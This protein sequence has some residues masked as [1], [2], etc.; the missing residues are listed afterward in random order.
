MNS[1]LTS[2]SGSRGHG[3][4]IQEAGLSGEKRL[5]NMSLPGGVAP[6][7]KGSLIALLG[8]HDILCQQDIFLPWIQHYLSIIEFSWK[9]PEE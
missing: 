7:K 4:G 6:L 2:L 8:K 1:R 5:T 3:D 9:E